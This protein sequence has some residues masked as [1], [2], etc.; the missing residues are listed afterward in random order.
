MMDLKSIDVS[1]TYWNDAGSYMYSKNPILLSEESPAQ[2][3]S[4]QG[5]GKV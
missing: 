1:Y 5:R 4:D 3:Q 2:K